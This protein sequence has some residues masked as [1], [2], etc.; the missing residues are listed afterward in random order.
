MSNSSNDEND[1]N[2]NSNSNTI[3]VNNYD[4]SSSGESD[5]FWLG[6]P[7]VARIHPSL[8]FRVEG[9]GFPGCHLAGCLAQLP[10]V[11]FRLAAAHMN[12]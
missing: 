2:R 7:G 11:C 6:G 8:G 4:N 10:W 12:E 3:D 1:D 5:L 9:L